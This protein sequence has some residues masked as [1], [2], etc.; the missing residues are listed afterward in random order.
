MYTLTHPLQHVS[1]KDHGRLGTLSTGGRTITS[2]RF[3]NDIDD[4]AGEEE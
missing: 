1:G 2:L 3:A 4:L